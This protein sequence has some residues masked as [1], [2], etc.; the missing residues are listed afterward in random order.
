MFYSEEFLKDK[1]QEY[2][3]SR[4][5]IESSVDPDEFIS[6]GFK[7][8]ILHRLPIYKKIAKNWG[9]T[10]M[11]EHLSNMN[12]HDDFVEIV[13]NAIDKKNKP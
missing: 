8:L 9:I 13:S 7:A 4:N 11:S 3:R 10:I 12:S 2:C 1:W 6:Y 5:K